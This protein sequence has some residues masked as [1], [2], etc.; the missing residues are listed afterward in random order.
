MLTSD[1]RISTPFDWCIGERSP[2]ETLPLELRRVV[3][4]R[5]TWGSGRCHE[6]HG[7]VLKCTRAEALGAEQ[8][9]RGATAKGRDGERAQRRENATARKRNGEKTQRRKGATGANIGTPLQTAESGSWRGDTA[10]SCGRGVVRP[11]RSSVAL[12]ALFRRCAPSPSRP[13]AV[14]LF[15]RRAPSLS[16][17]FAAA[18]FPP[19][20]PRSSTFACCRPY[21][22]SQ[23]IR[24]DH[25]DQPHISH[26]KSLY[27]P[28]R[29]RTRG[30]VHTR[31][32]APCD[33]V[34]GA[35]RHAA[36]GRAWRRSTRR[37]RRRG[38]WRSPG[39]A[40]RSGPG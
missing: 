4:A 37:W 1:F 32:L 23:R 29:G 33:A 27:P 11:R 25:R 17:P 20:A 22:F 26:D 21:A 10:A 16:R 3:R 39:R 28:P 40:V 5:S 19:V 7:S 9:A 38:R 30:R 2:I 18:A 24:P 14:A 34:A 13:F 6:W 35:Q 36:N 8:K 12:V 15:R 31:F